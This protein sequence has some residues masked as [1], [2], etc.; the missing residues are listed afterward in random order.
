MKKFLFLALFLPLASIAQ[1]AARGVGHLPTP[2][3]SNQSPRY[4]LPMAPMTG[5]PV[6]GSMMKM[7]PA[8]L[9]YMETAFQTTYDLQFA[10]SAGRRVAL[11]PD[12]SVGAVCNFSTKTN[13]WPDRGTAFNYFGGS[14]FA[15]GTHSGQRIESKRA[16]YPAITRVMD[17]GKERDL[18]V[19]HYASQTSTDSSGGLFIMENDAA[20]SDNFTVT[21]TTPMP[22]GPLW[23]KVAASG[24]YV[25][26]VANYFIT[27]NPKKDTVKLSGVRQPTVFYRYNLTTK[28]FDFN[29][30]V[31][32]GYDNTRYV[33]GSSDAYAIDAQDSHVV[34]AIAG[35][36]NDVA[37]WKSSDN[38]NNWSKMVVD[39]FKYAPYDQE[40]DTTLFK[41]AFT[42]DGS[43]DVILDKK[44]GVHLFYGLMTTINTTAGDSS[45]SL[46]LRSDRIVYYDDVNKKKMYIA[47][48]PDL[49]TNPQDTAVI[50]QGNFNSVKGSPY[51]VL[52][53]ARY[54]NSA[55]TTWPTVSI[56]DSGYIY[57]FFSSFCLDS[58]YG[59]TTA[60][61]DYRHIFYNYS[62]DN[63]IT[64]TFPID[65]SVAALGAT[66]DLPHEDV[67]ASV[68]RNADK[69]VY[70]LWQR[71]DEPGT[72]L[73]DADPEV[74]NE[75][76]FAVLT[77]PEL[78]SGK[79][80]GISAQTAPNFRLGMA[81][82]N[83][84]NASTS[85]PL[86]LTKGSDRVS[87][88]VTN[89]LGKDIY[90]NSYGVLPAGNNTLTFDVSSYGKGVYF[91]TIKVGENSITQKLIVE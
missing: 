52:S 36:N 12:G 42:N 90:Q 89:I 33:E 16:G 17:G 62:K 49:L 70:I 20:G 53:A 80:T 60:G 18:I 35:V 61:Q 32:P 9:V 14:S 39:T 81:Y 88:K 55:M 22:G 29:G 38:G 26:I 10:S 71:D 64:W 73:D 79:F 91:Y 74:L 68:T 48:N 11:H 78:L 24:N 58:T 69:N 77:T 13:S 41:S 75:I 54:G 3:N 72:A 27:N 31:L 43:V 40:K 37:Y 83:P 4:N 45:Y 51:P 86:S 25:Y 8:S 19:S 7:S 66:A 28:K 47:G 23:P 82:P 85:I 34:V 63:G 59:V 76:D 2:S 57:M 44:D 1:D 5:A 87:V 46:I 21:T 15:G 30:V 56:D 6:Q 67:F 50:Q 84:T 65:L